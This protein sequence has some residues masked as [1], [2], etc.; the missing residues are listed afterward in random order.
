MSSA[1][2]YYG[3]VIL[4]V[5]LIFV[6]IDYNKKIVIDENTNISTRT[7]Q[8]STINESINLGELIVN[9]KLTIN[10]EKAIELWIE[11]FKKN[12]DLNLKYKIEIIGIKEDP[13][14][15]AVRVRGYSEY[16]MLEIDCTVDYFN[17]IIVD[18]AIKLEE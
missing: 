14:A 18:D 16:T 2:K 10:E 5:I 17:L 4:F 1:V 6:S 11:N 9:Q 12:N 13:P 15:I 3:L 7:T 8:M